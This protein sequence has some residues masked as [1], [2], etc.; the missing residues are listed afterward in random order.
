MFLSPRT[1]E[2]L[3]ALKA[4]SSG[5]HAGVIIHGQSVHRTAARSFQYCPRPLLH[6]SALILVLIAPFP[7]SPDLPMLPCHD[8]FDMVA[9][10][11][12]D[13][14]SISLVLSCPS[15]IVVLFT[16]SASLGGGGCHAA[17]IYLSL[18]VAPGNKVT[19]QTEITARV[20]LA[21][22]ISMPSVCL[23]ARTD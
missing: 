11:P 20:V 5:E 21:E 14:Y 12:S 7:R 2:C 3:S 16:C 22:E 18:F 15:R 1:S 4:S 9:P 8:G 17:L 6:S 13:K 10:S 23:G 19:A